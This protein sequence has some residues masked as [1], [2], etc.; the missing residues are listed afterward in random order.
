MIHILQNKIEKE[1]NVLRDAC[2]PVKKAEFGT[3]E[4]RELIQKMQ[5]AAHQE[6]DGVAL[7]APQIGINK[8]IFVIDERAYNETAK[9]R[10]LIFINPE[11][12]KASRKQEIKEEGCLSVRGIW[13]KTWRA[14]TVTVKAYNVDGHPFTFGA[15]GLIAHI[16]Q[17]EYDH[18]DGVLFT[19]HGFDFSEYDPYAINN[20]HGHKA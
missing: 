5:D 4:L 20:E 16:I 9:F 19:D 6:P 18:L 8:A 13:G 15:A 11:I 10:P 12:Q 3:P 14:T 7:A 1:D 17:H 2:K